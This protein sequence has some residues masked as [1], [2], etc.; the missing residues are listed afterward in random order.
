MHSL[1]NWTDIQFILLLLIVIV[2]V[3]VGVC[4][5]CRS[6]QFYP[7]CCSATIVRNSHRSNGSLF[8]FS[9][10]FSSRDRASLWFWHFMQKLS[11]WSIWPPLISTFSS[12]ILQK[13]QSE[14]I[15]WEWNERKKKLK[16]K[17]M[18]LVNRT[19]FFFRT[20]T[21][22]G[23]MLREP[24]NTNSCDISFLHYFF[25][26]SFNFNFFILRCLHQ[27]MCVRSPEFEIYVGFT[28]VFL[29]T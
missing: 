26:Y 9:L 8:E 18:W 27:H 13:F 19:W 22:C 28:H 24:A 5:V 21:E 6:A 16:K 17:Q 4:F 29:I 12:F 3:M 15:N 23:Q 10:V 2:I 20:Q 25:L 1:D 11:V 14:T 7:L